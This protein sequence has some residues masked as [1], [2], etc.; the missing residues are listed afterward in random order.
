MDDYVDVVK[1]NNIN[2]V[3]LSVNTLN[4]N[5]FV[6]LSKYLKEKTDCIVIAG[7]VHIT[8][9]KEKALHSDVDYIFMGESD[10]SLPD[11]L[12]ALQAGHHEKFNSITGMMFYDGNNLINNGLALITDLDNLPI[13]NR[14]LIDYKQ[15]VTTLPNG[16][17]VLSTG[18]TASRGCPYR[19]VFCSEKILTGNRYRTHSPEYVFEEMKH[20]QDVFGI[21]HIN[22]Y[23]STFNI[24]KENVRRLCEL[25]IESGRKFTFWV[26]ARASLLDEEQLQIMKRAGLVRL[27]IAIESGNEEI[28]KLIKKNQTRAEL[29][30]AFSM[31]ND[32]NIST[33]AMAIIGNPADTIKTMFETAEFIRSI[34]T[35]DIT[36][37]GIAIPY[38]GTE[39]YDMANNNQH[40]LK[41]LTEDWD[42]Y[43]FYGLGV[44]EVNGLSPWQMS[45]LQKVLLTWTYLQV[46]KIS[47]VVRTH[48]FFPIIWSYLLFL[49]KPRR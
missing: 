31:A 41:L 49:F 29:L 32:A 35:L 45:M 30:R 40:G 28:L 42:K 11:F 19:C 38:P 7:G 36:S 43:H 47:S 6:R 14:E 23:D 2:V 5:Y 10:E 8:A 25:I 15:F 3:G 1:R 21:N 48:G 39:L 9:L 44:M 37:L 22:F 17:K 34:K 4:Y 46:R 16:Q 13:A 26:G 12:D 27:G 20:V 24:R 18:I 33:E